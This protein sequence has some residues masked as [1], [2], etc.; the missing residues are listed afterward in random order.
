MSKS[1]LVADDSAAMRQILDMTLRQ[2]GFNVTLAVHGQDALHKAFSAAAPFDVVLTD[3]NM[4]EM[5]GLE[6][7]RAL[8]ELAAY[9]S[10]PI[11][12]LTTEEGEPFKAA[13]REAGATGWLL[14]PLEP[15]I[16]TDLL[17]TLGEPERL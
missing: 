8:R 3:Q 5:T 9:V 4:P 12:I 1:I 7:I 10:T 11:L 13:A 2:A 16:L 17:A 6:L 14:K 15:Q